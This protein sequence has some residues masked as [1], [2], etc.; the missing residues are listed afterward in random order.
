MP[1]IQVSLPGD[2]AQQRVDPEGQT[3]DIQHTC[4]VTTVYTERLF[5]QLGILQEHQTQLVGNELLSSQ[6]SSSPSINLGAT[7]CRVTQIRNIGDLLSIPYSSSLLCSCP[8]TIG[9]VTKNC[10][11][12]PKMF[13]NPSSPLHPYHHCPGTGLVS[14]I[15]FIAQATYHSLIILHIATTATFLKHSSSHLFIVSL[16]LAYKLQQGRNCVSFVLYSILRTYVWHQ[17][18]LKYLLNLNMPCHFSA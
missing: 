12:T 3:K 5:L 17:W 10:H 8:S 2:R 1:V 6:S 18:V 11:F 15:W 16:P 14:F 9:D 7:I 13:S 4:F